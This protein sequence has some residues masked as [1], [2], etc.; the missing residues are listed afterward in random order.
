MTHSEAHNRLTLGSCIDLM[1]RIVYMNIKAKKLAA[2]AKTRA[3]H[4]QKPRHDTETTKELEAD[5]AV[6]YLN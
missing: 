4:E 1:G 3:Y 2:Q 6:M 5:C